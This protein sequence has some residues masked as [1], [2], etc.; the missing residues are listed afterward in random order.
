VQRVLLA[1]A[2]AAA[3]THA[4][5]ENLAPTTESILK[6]THDEHYIEGGLVKVR[7]AASGVE[8]MYAAALTDMGSLEREMLKIGAHFIQR[9]VG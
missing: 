1:D 7:D 4:D 9:E 6:S 8:V 5:L 3:Q 2:A